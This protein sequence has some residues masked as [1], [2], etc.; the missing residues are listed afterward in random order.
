LLCRVGS[1]YHDVGK[2]LKPR[3]FVENQEEQFNQ[4]K[5][6]SP[7]MSRMIIVGHVKDGLEL[8]REY[9]I[10]QVL[11]QFT[12]T[13]H[14]TTLV[15]Y[16]YHEAAKKGSE[17][18]QKVAETEFRYPGPKPATL[19]AAIVMLADA[20][21]GATRAMQ[22]PTPGRIESLVHNIAMKRLQDGQLDQCDL[23]MKSLHIIEQSLIKSLC[24]MYHARVAYPKAEKPGKIHTE[25]S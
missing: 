3:Y 9:K 10:P 19:E 22:D 15:E 20:V 12:A 14:G 11:Q 5:E 25:M 6:L 21:E 23:T 24:G 8:L 17:L 2:L 7:T 18:G 4:H 13:H 1:Y 16:F